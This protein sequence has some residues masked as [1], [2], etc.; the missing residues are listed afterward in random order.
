[1]CVVS[2]GLAR[3][4]GGTAG[5]VA[6]VT[7]LGAPFYVGQSAAQCADVP[8]SAFVALSASLLALAVSE[9]RHAGRERVTLALAG[10]AAS[11]AAWTKNEG[12]LFVLAGGLALVLV[13]HRQARLEARLR[14]LGWFLVGSSPVLVA[15]RLVQVVVRRSRTTSS[16][17]ASLDS[18]MSRVTDI[19]RYLR[20]AGAMATEPFTVGKWNGL[21]IVLAGATAWLRIGGLPT[22]ARLPALWLATVLAGFFAVYVLTPHGLDWH[23]VTS[24]DRLYVQLWPLAVLAAFLAMGDPDEWGRGQRGTS[25][26]FRSDPKGNEH[27]KRGWHLRRAVDH[28]QAQLGHLL[29]RVARA[30]AAEARVLHAAVRHVVDAVGRDV[31]D[32]DA[33]GLDGVERE[34][35]ALEVRREDARLQAERRPVDRGERVLEAVERG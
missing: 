6:G 1:M 8:V 24:L 27:P 11:L 32:E 30:F 14:R 19:G 35:G 31:V 22:A 15:A 12:L 29:D 9:D 18:V 13:D 17:P 33:A 25:T 26:R 23:L 16:R 21:P 2:G 10:A 7:L 3:L 34:Q 28:Q 5:A 20:V 4:R